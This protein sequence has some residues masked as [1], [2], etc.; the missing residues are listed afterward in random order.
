MH[1]HNSLR[2]NWAR[3]CRRSLPNSSGS[4]VGE[5]RLDRGACSRWAAV[6]PTP[7]DYASE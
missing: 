2:L 3:C 6:E 5:P 4:G 7:V 1:W